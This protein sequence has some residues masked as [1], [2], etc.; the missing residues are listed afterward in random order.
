RFLTVFALAMGLLP[1]QASAVP[2]EI[3][4]SSAKE[5]MAPRWCRISHALMEALQVLKFR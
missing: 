3:I 5:T 2:C 1:I 4:S